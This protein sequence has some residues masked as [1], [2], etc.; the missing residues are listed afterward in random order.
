VNQQAQQM[1]AFAR[2]ILDD[3]TSRGADTEGLR[4]LQVIE[5][6]Y[7]S[8]AAGGQRVEVPSGA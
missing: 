7:E 8:I 2:C 4:D 1:D 5:A 6:I 3:R